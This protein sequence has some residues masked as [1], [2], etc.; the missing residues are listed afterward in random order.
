MTSVCDEPVYNG[1]YK[2]NLKP[3]RNYIYYKCGDLEKAND[4]AQEALVKLWLFCS[5]VAFEKVE[6]FLYTVAKRLMYN[7]IRHEK[8]ILQFEK[9][10]VS[11]ASKQ[12]SPEFI[13]R[14]K[15]FSQQLELAISSLPENIRITFLMNRIDKLTFTEIA[16]QLEISVK[17]V[18]KRMQ[19]A[20]EELRENVKELKIYKI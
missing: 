4:L 13:M 1:L 5:S 12:Y 15:E 2:K 10:T 9:H 16:N 3:I 6:A 14:E 11:E 8:V 20:L 19:Q 17:T 18:E 7:M